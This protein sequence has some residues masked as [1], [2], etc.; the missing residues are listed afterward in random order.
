M[1]LGDLILI[2]RSELRYTRDVV[3]AEISH[4]LLETTCAAGVTDCQAA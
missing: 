3:A 2:G 4:Q 1:Q